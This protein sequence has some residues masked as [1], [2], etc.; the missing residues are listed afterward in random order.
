MTKMK[1]FRL[2]LRTIRLLDFLT[3]KTNHTQTEILDIALWNLMWAEMT[4]G[5]DGETITWSKDEYLH[6]K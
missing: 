6:G 2:D 3:K 4:I 5:P 1:S